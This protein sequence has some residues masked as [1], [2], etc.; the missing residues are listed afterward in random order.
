MC[1]LL[2]ANVMTR[3]MFALLALFLGLCLTLSIAVVI[4][5]FTSQACKRGFRYVRTYLKE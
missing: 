4:V 1:S 2:I 3:A 5:R